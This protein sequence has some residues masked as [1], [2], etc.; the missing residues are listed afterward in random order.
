MQHKKN[1]AVSLL[2]AIAIAAAWSCGGNEPRPETNAATETKVPD[3]IQASLDRGSY[4]V[5][6]VTACIDC[7]STRDYTKYSGPIIPGTE[8]KGG[9]RFGPEVGVPGELYAPNITPAALGS[10]TDEE[11]TRA[12]TEGINKKGDTLFPLMPYMSYAQMPKSD[13]QDIIR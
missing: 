3:S 12:I 2:T 4:L 10:W 13:I 5:H 6:H 9:E 7:H 1:R 8:G 11:I